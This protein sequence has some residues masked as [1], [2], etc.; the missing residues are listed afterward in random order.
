MPGML[1]PWLPLARD[2]T[3]SREEDTEPL[4]EALVEWSKRQM[5]MGHNL[6]L[7]FGVDEHPFATCFDV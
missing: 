1:G 5:A 3:G 7:H 6:W 2:D 4:A